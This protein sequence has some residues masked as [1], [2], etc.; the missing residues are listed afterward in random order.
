MRAVKEASAIGARITATALL[1]C[2][3]G[4]LWLKASLDWWEFRWLCYIGM[5]AI[6]GSAIKSIAEIH[7]LVRRYRYQLSLLLELAENTPRFEPGDGKILNEADLEALNAF[8]PN[9][10]QPYGELHGRPFFLTS[11][12]T[13]I[14]APAGEGKTTNRSLTSLAHGFRVHDRASKS[15]KVA[16]ALV[17]DVKKELGPMTKHLRKHIHGHEIRDIEPGSPQSDSYNAL[18]NVSDCLE[19][20]HIEEAVTR[21]GVLATLLE[22]EPPKGESRDKF[23]RDGPR[24]VLEFAMMTVLSLGEPHASLNDV[25]DLIFDESLFKQ[26]LD[27]AINSD[28]FA[29]ALQARA[30]MI[31]DNSKYYDQFMLTARQALKLFAA[32]G[33]LRSCSH[34][35]SFRFRD[36]KQQSITAYLSVSV[37]DQEVFQRW[38]AL[39]AECFCWEMVNHPGNV[40]VQLLLEEFTNIKFP[41]AEK[42]TA[43]RFAGI[44]VEMVVQQ[45]SELVRVLGEEQ[46]ETVWGEASIKIIYGGSHN[47]ALIDKVMAALGEKT[48]YSDSFMPGQC[49]DDDISQTRTK[50]KKPIMSASDIKLMKG[51]II[52]SRSGNIISNKL[53]F[54]CVDPWM[55]WVEKNPYESHSLEKRPSIKLSYRKV[56][57]QYRRVHVTRFK[58][59]GYDDELHG[60]KAGSLK[61]LWIR[62]AV[63]YGSV[64]ILILNF[65][66]IT[67]VSPRVLWNYSYKTQGHNTVYSVCQYLGLSDSVYLYDRYECP[68]FALLSEDQF[69][70]NPFH[71]P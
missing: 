51:Q 53:P 58:R 31:L 21:I 2:L 27:V 70:N 13:L 29:G 64:C 45:W 12:H 47:Q 69:S 10:G 71:K 22:P 68:I 46:A 67:G 40:P 55:H 63:F 15:S 62:F 54:Y 20:G 42:L 59:T 14:I 48:V 35:S 57:S 49:P 25:A 24:T 37:S 32:G 4:W 39:I 61:N 56:D 16:S 3:A 11:V 26:S 6:L 19:N 44:R 34:K 30:N 9:V 8:D 36:M 33:Q 52:L 5:F 38:M 60:N 66:S 7:Y 17:V 41:I 43:L 65:Q 18:D 1:I 50:T 28:D 23:W